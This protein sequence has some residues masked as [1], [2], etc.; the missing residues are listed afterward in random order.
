MFHPL[1]LCTRVTSTLSALLPLLM[2]TQQ[3]KWSGI[4]VG[5]HPALEVL[6]VPLLGCLE[7]L[8]EKSDS[9]CHQGGSISGSNSSG[10]FGNW[11]SSSSSSIEG[12]CQFIL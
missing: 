5:Q 11:F 12:K 10:L 4:E 8:K 9:K 7:M 6:F 1:E 3:T 2:S